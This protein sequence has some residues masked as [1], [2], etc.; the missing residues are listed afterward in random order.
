MRLNQF[1]AQATSLSR[2]KADAAIANGRVRVNGQEPELG[3]QV[4]NKDEIALDGKVLV[5]A[6]VQTIILNKPVGYVVSRDGQG[7]KTVYDLLP[8][9]MQGLKPVGRLD[10]DSSG[11]L[12][13]TN[14]GN[15]ANQLTHPRYKKEKAYQVEINKPLALSDFEAITKKGVELEDGISRFEVQDAEFGENQS[16]TM[17]VRMHEGKNRQIRRTFAALGYKVTKLHRTQFGPYTLGQLEQG[18]TKTVV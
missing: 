16:K 11:L 3:Q 5:L 7:S 1:I 15:L 8:P 6:S 2:R 18:R 13:L 10:K 12:L 9:E 17:L 14:D 4:S